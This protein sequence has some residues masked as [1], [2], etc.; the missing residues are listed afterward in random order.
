M[1]TPAALPRRT[2]SRLSGYLLLACAPFALA[3][4]AAIAQE[5]PQEM[6]QQVA[7]T[8]QQTDPPGRIARLDY[9]SGAVTTEPAG[10]SDWSYAAL[11]RP[12]TT[13]DQLW[14]DVHARSEL[15]IG[16]T[17]VRL[18]ASTSLSLLNLDDTH[19]QLKVAQGTLS[20]HVREFAP[21]SSYEI[22]TPNAALGV[23]APGDYRVDVAPDGST[24]TVTVRA[25]SVT[26]YGDGGQMPMQAGQQITFSGTNLQQ[27]ASNGVPPP[28]AFDQWA[29]RR[30][31]A[32]THS[33]SARYVSRDI[34]GYQDLDANGS[35]S[36]NPQYGAVWMPNSVPAGWAPYHEGHWVWQ[37]PWG[38][39]WVDD[40]PWG[41][42]PY[43]Y[44]RWAYLGDRWA[45]VPGPLVVSAPPPV[46]AP[47]LVA[48]VGGGGGGLSW[49][50]DLTIGGAAAAG[51]AWFPLG[52]G[53][54]WH[55][56]WG[57]WSPRYYERVNQTVIV[58]R[59][60][61]V[62]NINNIHNTYI[63][64][65]A[66]GAVTAVPATA[67][68][69]GQPVMRFA[70]KVDPRQWRNTRINAGAPAIAPVQQSF[71]PG[72]R[73]ATSRPP[74]AV[75]AR[76]I[77]AT[78][79]PAVPAAFHDQ[80]AQRFA[81]SGDKVPGAGAPVVRTA[82][83]GLATQPAHGA[84]GAPSGAG[85]HDVRLVSPHSPPITP[86]H[87]VAQAAH[88]P[89]PL[90]PAPR[91]PAVPAPS[92]ARP[93]PGQA[94][95]HTPM[96]AAHDRPG[97]GVPH[98]PQPMDNMH[99]APHEG[100]QH[101]P[102]PA[103]PHSPMALQPHGEPGHETQPRVPAYAPQ[104]GEPRPEPRVPLATPNAESHPAFQPR[105]A[106]PQPQSQPALQPRAQPQPEHRSEPPQPAPRIE[107]PHAQP[108]PAPRIEPHVQP[109]PQPRPPQPANNR[110][111][112]K[113][114]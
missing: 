104:G 58:N 60:V 32:E 102:T 54:V 87:E 3:S 90:T 70:Q 8:A 24:T 50:I 21:G 64:Y 80:L 31:A 27:V 74:Q 42:A 83:V 106:Q 72:L 30:D 89:T 13:G 93:E 1:K 61:N 48:F 20:A 45:W 99:G 11:N 25:G 68:V 96:A 22:D 35:W 85:T 73:A 38:W 26:V 81:R 105:E 71:A 66:P 41:F 39:T 4:P 86:M 88:G 29:A 28:D 77:V 19:A 57:G 59:N 94:V 10:A 112:H 84:L 111:E 92:A 69:H 113:H 52:P 55:P 110:D 97:N 95:P 14:N 36:E 76:P 47:A 12:L 53:E 114:E 23:S 51:V 75:V 65:R 34:P 108:Q 107:P 49:G 56:S 63:N 100:P 33:I 98:P 7:A 44:G 15:H 2:V 62:T 5:P 37:A 9:M 109:Q 43:H 79:N 101:A 18:S 46:Y 16:S 6:P 103:E 67:F 40:A 78:R 82:P 17:A 91:E